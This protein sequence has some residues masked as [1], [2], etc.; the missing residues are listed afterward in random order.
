MKY[1][2]TTYIIIMS[3]LK[4]ITLCCYASLDCGQ[5]IF[6]IKNSDY[7]LKV[8]FYSP[9]TEQRYGFLYCPISYIKLLFILYFFV[10]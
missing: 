10:Y 3:K 7:V 6:I 1:T 9:L 2:R 5:N 8:L 4:A